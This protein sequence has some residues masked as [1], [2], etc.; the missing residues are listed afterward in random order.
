MPGLVALRK[1]DTR[2]REEIVP[3]RF[4][5]NDD[6]PSPLT[7]D[8]HFTHLWWEGNILGEPHGLAAVGLE[9]RSPY[10]HEH[11]SKMAYTDSISQWICQWHIQP[12]EAFVARSH[13]GGELVAADMRRPAPPMRPFAHMRLDLGEG[14]PAAIDMVDRSGIRAFAVVGTVQPQHRR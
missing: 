10:T 5:R 6:A 12:S 2:G 9:K 8:N 14:A 4:G 7:D 3:D 1:V 13:A 11:T